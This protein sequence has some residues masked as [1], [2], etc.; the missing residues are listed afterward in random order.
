MSN[1]AK[2]LPGVQ[3]R[4]RYMRMDTA[5]ILKRYFFCEQALVL[6]QAGW[7][8]AIP[9]LEAKIA[10]PQFFWEDALT[11]HALRERVFELR[12]PSRLLEVADD[13]PIVAVF[14][15]AIHAPSP[16][17]FV[18]SLA[19]VYKPAQLQAYRAYLDI[20][21]AIADG[22]SLRFLQMAVT[23]KAAQITTLAHF[24]QQMHG[25]ATPAERDTAAAW[26]AA[27]QQ[28]MQATGGLSVDRPTPENGPLPTAALRH[29]F[30]LAQEA[31]H[32]AR[33]Q[34]CRYYWPNVV[35]PTF[36]Y[37]DGVLLQL[38]SA[39]SHLNE[40]W[41]VET[42]G[43]ILQALGE[44]LG[45]EFI[46]DA[47]R[48]TYDEAR[49]TRMGYDRLLSWG[50]TPADLPLGSYIYDSA[51]GEPA[52][53]RLGMLHYFETKNIGK[54][55]ERAAA[56]ESYQDDA[57]QHDMEFDWADETIHAHYGSKWIKA[58]RERHP[59]LMDKD[60][61]LQ[62][63]EQLVDNMVHSATDADR[64]RIHEVA[65]AMIARAEAW[66]VALPQ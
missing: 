20:A 32:D 5:R 30:A 12:F 10:I 25:H 51:R 7:L 26:V 54:K 62:H 13:A 50:Y 56:F 28:R 59:D 1:E 3:A 33:F 16:L 46:L 8:A 36:A 29:P 52:Y 34:V 31:A 42:G 24:A 27:L 53:T 38:R 23:D 49:H 6:A 60:A 4:A 44:E 19:Q 57:S 55:H 18:Q 61:L 11:G 45:W 65:T 47:A 41:A 58:L 21:D 37:G 43:A 2:Y 66:A 48:W 64:Q 9:D 15:E 22:P 35:D 14:E 40:V 39:V 63:C 17:A